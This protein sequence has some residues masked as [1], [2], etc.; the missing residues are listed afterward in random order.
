VDF[1]F[2]A[3]QDELRDTVRR[4]LAARAPLESLRAHYGDAHGCGDDLWRGLVE[5]GVVGL[6]APDAVGG[7]GRGMVDAA[8][9]LEEMGRAVCP[10]PY[11]AT[12]VGAVGLVND[13]DGW[14]SSPALA[15]LATG[16]RRGVVAVYEPERRAAWRAPATRAER[17]GAEFAV[18]GTKA[19]VDGG[20]G[21][22]VLLVVA[23][24]DDGLAVLAV[25]A[26]EAEVTHT[27]T[28]DGSRAE[29]TV[30]LEDAPGRGVGGGD[31]A[32]AV[33]RTLDRVAAGAVVDGV[34]AAGRAL[35]LSVE[36]AKA[37]RQFGAPI[38]SFQAVQHLCADMLRAV[39]MARAAGYYACWAA[40]AAGP[41]EAHRAATMALAFAAD[42]L[43]GVGA[44]TIQVHGGIGF[45]WEHDAHLFYKR[46]LTLQRTGGGS[47]DQLAELAALLLDDGDVSASA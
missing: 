31:A 23:G 22:D 2:T 7:A 34:G 36:Y 24:T 32:A 44:A 35:E 33:A 19:H 9:V 15:G 46:L 13:L 38:G 43:A 39:E 11:L 8:V 42:E 41:A 47:V 1:E 40:D 45:T 30:T 5:L 26:A 12:A 29:A 27:P 17:R 14:S 20:P 37:R 21:A 6:L 18:T 25:D 28:V 16:E 10:C 3:E 4:F